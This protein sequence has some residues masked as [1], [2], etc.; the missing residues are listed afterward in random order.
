MTSVN[1]GHLLRQLI[2]NNF[3]HQTGSGGRQDAKRLT[4]EQSVD[5]AADSARHYIFDSALKSEDDVRYG[6]GLSLDTYDV[7]VQC[8]SHNAA[9]RNDFGDICEEKEDSCRYGLRYSP[10]RYVGKVGQVPRH[11]AFDIVN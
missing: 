2:E 3:E 4:R 11:F 10:F 5:D 1:S 8:V 9:K 7:V 6:I